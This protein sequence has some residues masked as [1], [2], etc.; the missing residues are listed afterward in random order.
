MLSGIAAF[1]R[2]PVFLA[3]LRPIFFGWY[4]MKPDVQPALGAYHGMPF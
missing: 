1:Q 3:V 4:M 2:I